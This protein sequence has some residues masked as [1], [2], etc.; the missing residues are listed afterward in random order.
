MKISILNCCMMQNLSDKLLFQ[1]RRSMEVKNE[2]VKNR[3]VAD[4]AL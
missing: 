4:C 1:N 3:I 2:L